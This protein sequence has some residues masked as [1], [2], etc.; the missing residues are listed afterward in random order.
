MNLGGRLK[1]TIDELCE[2]LPVGEL[3]I[4]RG[5]RSAAALHNDEFDD[6]LLEVVVFGEAQKHPQEGGSCA[7]ATPS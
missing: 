6:L 3:T 4:A 7:A 5:A 2:S 1:K